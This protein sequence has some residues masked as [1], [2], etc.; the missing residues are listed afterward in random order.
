MLVHLLPEK[1]T[2]TRSICVIETVLISLAD[3]IADAVLV[4]L[5]VHPAIIVELLVVLCIDIELRPNG[6]HHTA[7][8]VMDRVHHS[9]WVREAGRIELMASPCIL[10][11]M[12]PV[13]HDVIDRDIPLSEALESLDHLGRC[14]I[15][16]AALPISH[17]PLRHNRGLSCQSTVTADDLVHVIASDEVPIHLLCHLAPPLMLSLLHRIHDI[18]RTQTAV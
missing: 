16:L 6:N 3:P 14:L 4:C 5:V 12:A 15:P 11:P 10:F 2:G 9:L 7:A 18:I 17:G 13:H 8:E 1:F